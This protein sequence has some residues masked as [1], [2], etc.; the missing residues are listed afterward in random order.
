MQDSTAQ[1]KRHAL[2]LQTKKT[3]IDKGRFKGE[4]QGKFDRISLEG[5]MRRLHAD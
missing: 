3:E 1:Q 2:W 5:Q 4:D